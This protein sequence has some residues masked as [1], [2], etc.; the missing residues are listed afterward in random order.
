MIAL[1]NLRPESARAT[2]IECLESLP[3]PPAL[4]WSGFLIRST[5]QLIVG[6]VVQWCADVREARPAVPV[7]IVVRPD[8]DSLRVIASNCL[9]F[10]PVLIP[11]DTPNGRVESEVLDCIRQK[12]VAARVAE[13]WLHRYGRIDP[14][15]LAVLHALAAHAVRGGRTKNI[16]N[17]TGA[18]LATVARCLRGWRYP[19]PGVLLRDGR[20]ASVQFRV[21]SGIDPQI[22]R[23]AA[24]WH[25]AETYAKARKRFRDDVKWGGVTRNG[26]GGKFDIP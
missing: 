17:S 3:E 26:P 1:V 2:G 18:S 14:G 19:P 9:V 7:G 12:S 5:R 24:G 13:R 20:I 11:D 10:E 8:A 23:E 22:A 25:S 16:E 15:E 4:R 6:D 21:E